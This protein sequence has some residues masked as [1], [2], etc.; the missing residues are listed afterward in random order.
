MSEAAGPVLFC[1]DGSESSATAIAVAKHLLARRTALVCH[2]P[3]FV[4]ERRMHLGIKERAERPAGGTG[5]PIAEALTKR[6]GTE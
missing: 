5:S 3:H 4:M 2:V 6:A 1:Y